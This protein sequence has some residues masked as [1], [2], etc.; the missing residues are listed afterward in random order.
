[1]RTATRVILLFLLITNI[2]LAQENWQQFKAEKAKY[3]STLEQVGVENFSCLI[4]SNDYIRFINK[5]ADSTFFYP[6]KIVWMKEGKVYYIMQPYPPD[7]SDSIQQQFLNKIEGLKKVFKGILSDWQQFSFFIP[8]KDI[9]DSAMVNFNSDTVGTSFRVSEKGTTISLKKTFT[10]AGELAR[11]VWSSGDLRIATY[12]YY[13][14]IEGKWVCQRWKS[15][16]YQ[17]GRI[18]SGLM[19]SLDLEKVEKAWFPNKFEIIAQSQNNPAQK[20]VIQ[21]FLKDYILNDK[22]EIVST[23]SEQTN[24][25]AK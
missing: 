1:M 9:P 5:I 8:Y 10:I 17:N 16:F 11:V 6:L 2:I 22:F 23:P 18:T 24:Q 15:Q 3:Y 12:P 7:L 20:S 14:E 25:Q 19:V 4:S 13:N 21:L